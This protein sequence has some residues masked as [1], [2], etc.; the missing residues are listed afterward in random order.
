MCDEKYSQLAKWNS[1]QAQVHSLVINT[2]AVLTSVGICHQSPGV[3]IQNQQNSMTSRTFLMFWCLTWSLLQHFLLL[4]LMSA[5]GLAAYST[6]RHTTC[7]LGSVWLHKICLVTLITIYY[8]CLRNTSWEHLCRT[9]GLQHSQ[10]YCMSSQPV[11][12]L[13]KKLPLTPQS[14]CSQ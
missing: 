13:I 4:L 8:R 10:T 11:M 9:G 3:C 14:K 5:L 12:T 7:P 2:A 1:R 6:C